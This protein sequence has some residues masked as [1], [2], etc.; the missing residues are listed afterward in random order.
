MLKDTL[1][2]RQKAWMLQQA[3]TGSVS[4]GV[5]L[6]KRLSSSSIS[7]VSTTTITP[8][9][10]IPA[11][12]NNIQSGSFKQKYSNTTENSDEVGPGH[13]SKS[14]LGAESTP[15]SRSAIGPPSMMLIANTTIASKGRGRPR[16]QVVYTG[17]NVDNEKRVNLFSY[18]LL[19]CVGVD[20]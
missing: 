3:A 19:I 13:S 9:S 11:L 16:K 1:E 4:L 12:T 2:N 17:P 6:K 5:A 8:N 10:I 7:T 15:S 20:S 18:Q 14:A